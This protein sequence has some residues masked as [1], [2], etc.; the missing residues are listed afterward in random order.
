MLLDSFKNVLKPGRIPEYKLGV[1]GNYDPSSDRSVKTAREKFQED[2]IVLLEILPEFV[3]LSK[4]TEKAP[5]E[6]EL[7]RGLRLMFNSHQIPLWLVFATQIF[8]DIHHLLRQDIAR[9]H[10]ELYQSAKAI[11]GSIEQNL[12]FHTSLRVDTWPASN[13]LV[14]KNIQGQLDAWVAKDQIQLAKQKIGHSAGEPFKLLKQHPL[15]CGLLMYGFKALFQEVGIAFSGAWGS[16]MYSGHLYHAVRNEK[17]L[18]KQWR[19]MEL[20]TFLQGPEH[21]F[22]GDE[23]RTAE[24]YLKKFCLSMGYSATAFARNRRKGSLEASKKGPKGLVELAPVSQLFKDRYCHGSGRVNLTLQDVEKILSESEWEEEAE[25]DDGIANTDKNTLVLS[26]NQ[27]P[28]N[29]K[30][31]P[32]QYLPATQLL[33]SLR[34][35]LQGETLEFTFDYL[36]MH[37][38]CW[39]LLRQVKESC[40]KSLREM[41]GPGYLEQENQLPFTVGYIFMAATDTKKLDVLLSDKLSDAVTSELMKQAASVI[42]GMIVTG[43]GDFISTKILEEQYGLVFEVE[44]D[45]EANEE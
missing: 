6:D 17:F 13:D 32:H 35:A 42:E 1:F 27:A 37:R 40:D 39:R 18:N 19:D 29:R 41:Y 4:L 22:V 44:E 7:T 30:W 3:V 24:E 20:V 12:A 16:I 45:G 34:N 25:G 15:F 43:A 36:L 5:A 33:E 14:L 21:F 11:N 9:G 2:K 28:K 38:F 23:P 31:G 10:A 26:R 8:L